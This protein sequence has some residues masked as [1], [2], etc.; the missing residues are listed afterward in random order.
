MSASLGKTVPSSRFFASN[1]IY[2]S[3]SRLGS[4]PGRHLKRIPLVLHDFGNHQVR[5]AHEVH[6][7]RRSDV[8]T[9]RFAN[10]LDH[11]PCTRLESREDT[12]PN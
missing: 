11:R 8:R 1:L 3:T 5:F 7:I 10:D 9:V 6:F 4:E 12:M 2:R